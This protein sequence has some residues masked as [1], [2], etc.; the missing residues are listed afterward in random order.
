MIKR[1]NKSRKSICFNHLSLSLSLSRS[2]LLFFT[3][4]FKFDK[5]FK[6]NYSYAYQKLVDICILLGDTKIFHQKLLII[7]SYQLE[8]SV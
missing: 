8:I 1:L 5:S 2:V 3:E 7:F 6:L 4:E